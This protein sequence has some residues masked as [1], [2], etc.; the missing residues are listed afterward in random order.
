MKIK[1]IKINKVVVIIIL[2]VMPQVN[3]NNKLNYKE[4]VKIHK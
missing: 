1:I 3:N 2:V 4:R